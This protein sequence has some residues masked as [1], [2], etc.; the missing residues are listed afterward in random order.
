MAGLIGV[1]G[2][3]FDPPH[4]GHLILAESGRQALGLDKVQWVV[5]AQP[6]HKPNENRTPVELRLEMVAAAIQGNEA[7]EISRV[8]VDR[9]PPHYAVDTLRLLA[10]ARPDASFA[11][12]LGEDSLRDLPVWHRP[13]QLVQACDVFGVME[14]SGAEPDLA[15]LEKVLPGLSARV[16][17]FRAPIID[18]ASRDL[19]RRVLAG[20]SIRYLVPEGVEQIIR[21]DGLY[22]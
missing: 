5:T 12:L 21:R 9:P 6:P 14:R 7:F 22:R 4:L 15:D 1:F 13:Q 18:I 10:A 3:T 19:R 20:E 8:D 2:G 11:Y 17:F 16:R